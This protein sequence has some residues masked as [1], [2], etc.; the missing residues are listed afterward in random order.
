MH[1]F[2]HRD[3]WLFSAE[4]SKNKTFVIFDN[5]HEPFADHKTS[6]YI[7]FIIKKKFFQSTFD[8]N[9]H[10]NSKR[11]IRFVQYEILDTRKKEQYRGLSLIVLRCKWYFNTMQS[12]IWKSTSRETAS[13]FRNGGCTTTEFVTRSRLFPSV[14]ADGCAW[15]E[16]LPSSKWL[17]SLARWEIIT[18][19]T[20]NCRDDKEKKERFC[21]T[22][23]S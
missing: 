8:A 9:F 18:V 3:W 20:L 1:E 19:S 15:D 11:P 6:I 7:T 23:L 12:V 22:R 4:R 10:E 16:D 2:R 5:C 13:F 17:S 21:R 14:T